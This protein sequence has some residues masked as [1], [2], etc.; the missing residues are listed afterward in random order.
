MRHYSVQTQT[1]FVL[2][3]EVIT[4]DIPC[5]FHLN[6]TSLSLNKENPEVKE[7]RVI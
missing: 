2:K 5:M 1:P 4:L 3:I 6:S 7:D